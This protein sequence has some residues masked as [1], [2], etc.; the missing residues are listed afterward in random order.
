[1]DNE[2]NNET[3]ELMQPPVIRI[4]TMWALLWHRSDILGYFYISN[5]GLMYY[6]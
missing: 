3:Q 4:C 6:R 1:M 2:R 5:T